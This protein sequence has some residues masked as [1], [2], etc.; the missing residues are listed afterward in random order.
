[1]LKYSN[2]FSASIDHERCG[3]TDREAYAMTMEEESILRTKS[4]SI[5]YE[6]WR[7]KRNRRQYHQKYSERKRND[8]EYKTKRSNYFKEFYHNKKTKN[9][10]IILNVDDL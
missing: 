4:A 9:S 10:N 1:L 2:N 5:K 3:C 6:K 7:K 8:E